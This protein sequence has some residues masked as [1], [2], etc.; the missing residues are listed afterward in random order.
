MFNDSGA[1]FSECGLYRYKLWRC[2]D[3]DKPLV[4][5]IGLNPS[6]AGAEKNDNT[7]TKVTKVAA[8]NGYGGLYMCNLF[9]LISKDPDAL[10]H[11]ADPLKEN[12]LHIAETAAICK[13][14]VFCW[15]AFKQ[16]QQRPEKRADRMKALFPAALCFKKTK[17]GAPWHPLYCLDKTKFTPF[18]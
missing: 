9:A 2:W 7:I 17:A 5:F 10:L 1:L 11:C 12:D 4:M 14:V 15:G 6:K 16:I 13:D 18:N 8:Y 3:A